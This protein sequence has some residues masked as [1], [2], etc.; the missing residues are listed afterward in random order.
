VAPQA[1]LR[2][3]LAA[4]ARLA[5]P[6]EFTR[7]AFLNGRIDLT[8][9]EAVMDLVQARTER[10]AQVA[11]AQLA[12]ALGAA[13]AACYE[14]VAGL[15]AEVE[16]RLDFESDELPQRVKQ[17]ELKRVA[18]VREK[19][20]G[21]LSTW[22]E[23]Q[24]LRSGALVVIGGCPNAGKSSLLNALLGWNRAIVSSSPGT[25]R[26]TIEE[27]LELNGI[28]LRLV[29]TAGLR[30]VSC[31]VEQEGVRRAG[32]ALAQADLMI[33]LLD[34]SRPLAEQHPQLFEK[35]F[36]TD[37]SRVIV[38]LNKTDL[39]RQLTTAAALQG[40]R[41]MRPTRIIELSA[42]TGQGLAELR[43][44]MVEKLGLEQQAPTQPSVSERHRDELRL[45]DQ[46]LD[47]AQKLLG[48]DD[49]QLVLAAI[50]LKDAAEALG[51]ITGNHYS[52]ELLDRIFARFCLGK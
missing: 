39:P 48:Q 3:V 45:A 41:H 28:Q 15:C 16:A 34:G 37:T 21:L 43:Q 25:T 42:L 4:G 6:G 2:V 52:L 35:V 20:A 24:L 31:P 50:K 23:S 38:A 10:A 49:Q 26:D 33:Y 1:V 7:R 30:D 51:R 8:Q 9:A 11:R 32:S 18:G 27:S 22:R 14:E 47:T 36:G 46:A 44:A 17:E 19:L 5:N 12:G 29:D 13:C 40:L